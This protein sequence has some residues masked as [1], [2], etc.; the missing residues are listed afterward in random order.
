MDL[1]TKEKGGVSFRHGG[2][3]ACLNS[4]K[5]FISY[6]DELLENA[7]F[8]YVI[9]GG[10]GTGKS[11]LAA[12]IARQAEAR[13][14]EVLRI[15]CSSDPDSLDGLLLPERG[16]ALVDGTAPHARDLK[17]PGVDS[18]FLDT[19]RFWDVG[20]LRARAQEIAR[21][22]EEKSACF[23]RGYLLLAASKNALDAAENLVRP[24]LDE[25]LLRKT[26]RRYLPRAA[27][28][29]A[30]SKRVPLASLGM[31]GAVYLDT[32]IACAE[33]IL[34]L[35]PLYGV[36]FLLLEEMRREAEARGVCCALSPDPVSLYPD[37][38]FFPQTGLLVRRGRALEK[39]NEKVLSLRRLLPSGKETKE[40]RARLKEL[41]GQASALYASAK[42][43]FSAA[44]APHFALESIYGEAMDYT[45][46][47]ALKEETA[48][49]IFQS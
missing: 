25:G 7:G 19:G 3:F 26:A 13:G 6:F 17:T 35:Q 49:R 37:S 45:G 33:R 40:N 28:L 2:Q 46:V 43:A 29:Q 8:V 12:H 47:D 44:S 9:K 42:E 18:V 34:T 31:K 39:E 10:P 38:L 16:I 22:N 41:C 1:H 21:L 36:E 4:G 32:Q 5:G 20:R 48:R 11:G 30:P 14:E 23:K 24:M 15:R 27:G